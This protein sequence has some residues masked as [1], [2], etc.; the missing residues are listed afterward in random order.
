MKALSKPCPV[1]GTLHV[2][3]T[4]AKQ[5]RPGETP[6]EINWRVTCEH[7]FYLIEKVQE[8]EEKIKENK[9]GQ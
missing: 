4:P 5:M 1:C 8:L 9:I 6:C 2:P 3:G 7:F